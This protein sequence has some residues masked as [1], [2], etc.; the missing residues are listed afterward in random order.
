MNTQGTSVE[1]VTY[2]AR[3]GYIYPS[4]H[5]KEFGLA[6]INSG[7]WTQNKRRRKMRHYNNH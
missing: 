2:Y 1:L 7:A 6:L 3:M 5:P 4:I